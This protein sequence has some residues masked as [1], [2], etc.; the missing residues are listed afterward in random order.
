MEKF[1]Y[2]VEIV[3]Y[4]PLLKRRLNEYGIKGWELIQI[5]TTIEEEGIYIVTKTCSYTYTFKRKLN[6]S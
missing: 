3:K 5:N 1:E 4:H 2:A 6:D